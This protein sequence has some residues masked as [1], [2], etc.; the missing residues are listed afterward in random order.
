[1]VYRT[2]QEKLGLREDKDPKHGL[3]ERQRWGTECMGV[4]KSIETKT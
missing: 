4:S 2:G 1:M 3:A